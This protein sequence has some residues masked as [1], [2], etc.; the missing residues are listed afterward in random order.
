MR[1][2]VLLLAAG[3]GTRLATAG[4]PDA[5]QFLPLHGA[6]LYWASARTMAHVAG[7]E[8]IVFVFPPHRVEEE[9]ARISALDDGSVLGLDWHVV[10]GGA[11]RQ[12]SVA[13][14]L[15]ALP[16]SCEAVL[17]HDAARPFASPALVARVLSALHDGHAGVVPG[18]P[19]TDTVKETTDGFV[20]NTPDRSRLV[21][22]QTPQGFTLKALSTAHETARTA[23]W[24][25]TDDAA[26]LERCG[27]PV[28]IVAGEV[29]NAK[30]TTPED[31]AMLDANEPQVTV[32]C[33]GWGY[34]VHRYGEGRPM[35]L[36]GVLIPEGPEVVAHSDGDVLLHALADALLGCI[37]AGDIGLHFPDSDAAFDNAN[38]AMLLDRVL[39][40]AHEARLRLTH[41]DLTIVAQV[42]KLS[43][44]RDK[45]R[46]NVARLLDLPVTSV[47]FKATTEEGLGFTG[48]KRGIK[49]IAAVTGLRP[50]P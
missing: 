47:N 36:G 16:R 8:G 41:V 21:A 6:P 12:D 26:L 27:I 25:V 4:L 5:K 17:V 15:A 46:A 40:M 32:P 39:H 38:S 34:D 24:N 29:V 9:R 7:I 19:L 3:S 11:A 37:G 48:E 13:C 33:V 44:W 45:I 42:P 2:W 49:A 35:K 18:I 28:R 30:I 1:T 23:G 50:M 20:A 10:G 22:V 43:P 31:L 14:G